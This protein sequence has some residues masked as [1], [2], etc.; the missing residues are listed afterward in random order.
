MKNLLF[1]ILILPISLSAQFNKGDKFLG[2]TLGFQIQQSPYTGTNFLTKS[3]GFAISPQIGFLLNEKLALGGN[4]GYSTSHFSIGPDTAESTND[5]SNFSIGLF[6][7]RYYSINDKFLFSLTGNADYGK[8]TI[9]SSSDI[10]N[11]ESKNYIYSISVYPS[12]I[13]FPS[14]K[15]GIEASIGNIKFSHTKTIDSEDKTDTFGIGYG[16]IF[17]GFAYYFQKINITI[18]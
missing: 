18:N 15:W 6:L 2:G 10:S 1:V 8:G 3:N 4:L 14:K 9:K 16:T 17:L 7:R 12:F 5:L 11:E 13:F